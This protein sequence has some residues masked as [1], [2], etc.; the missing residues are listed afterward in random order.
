MKRFSSLAAIGLGVFLLVG[1]VRAAG[2]SDAPPTAAAGPSQPAKPLSYLSVSEDLQDMRYRHLWIAYGVVWFLV[3]AF[4]WRTW[5]LQRTTS[6]ELDDLRG[7][8][9]D[10]EEGKGDG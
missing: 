3:F 4:V 7:R 6:D 2:P 5:K 1:P 9:A 10:L 8:I